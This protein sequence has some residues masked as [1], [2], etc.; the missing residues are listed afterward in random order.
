MKLKIA[1]VVLL[2]MVLSIGI[3]N[4]ASAHP[5]GYRYGWCRPHIGVRVVVSPVV[6]GAYAPAYYGAYG[7]PRPYG[8]RPAYRPRY[9]GYRYG[10]RRW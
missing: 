2:I 1:A 8:C 6:V 10:C 3:S 7:Y 5:W 4:S 9:Y